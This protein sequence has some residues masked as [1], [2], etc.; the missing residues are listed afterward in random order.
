MLDS[1]FF[2]YYI[3]FFI[4][5]F[6][7]KNQV[8]GGVF[9]PNHLADKDYAVSIKTVS[10]SQQTVDQAKSELKRDDISM[11]NTDI[12]S[13]KKGRYRKRRT[14]IK[15][16]QPYKLAKKGVH[17]KQEKKNR[18]SKKQ[19]RQ[20]KTKKTI[21]TRVSKLSSNPIFKDIFN[22]NGVPKS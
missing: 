19:K 1:F 14:S 20:K 3:H 22:K 12:V 2:I 10:P 11:I 15:R 21:K 17:T 16:Q 4:H 5:F 8:G 9:L 7:N 13:K 6:K 18:K